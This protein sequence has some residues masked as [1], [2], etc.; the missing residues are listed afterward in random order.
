MRL[1]GSVI[2]KSIF[3][4]IGINRGTSAPLCCKKSKSIR[5]HVDPQEIAFINADRFERISG[6]ISGSEMNAYERLLLPENLIYAWR[7][8]KNLYRTADGYIDYAELARFELDLEQQLNRI[9]GQ[10]ASGHYTLAALRPLPRPNRTVK[11]VS[12]GNIIMWQSSQVAWI[13]VANALGP[14]L[15]QKM[16]PWSYGNRIYRP[17]W[18]D[19]SEA[20]KS[21]LEIGPYRHES[22]HLYRKF[23]VAGL[24]FGDISRSPPKQW[25]GGLRATISISPRN[26]R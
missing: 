12:T 5:G 25:R 18:Y 3:Y 16:P 7:K 1:S 24:C 8:A 15:D 13:A 4:S 21:K 6:G 19:K 17:A 23:S 26:S 10:F 20:S 22:G 11:N 2:A 14:E 9:H